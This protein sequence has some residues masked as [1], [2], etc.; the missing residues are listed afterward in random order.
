MC[1]VRA[2]FSSTT[3]PDCPALESILPRLRAGAQACDQTGEW[4]AGDWADLCAVG[5]TRWVLPRDFGGDELS[6]LEL[7][8]K[9]ERIASASLAAAL[10]LT[11][12]D[13]AI[14]LIAG[15]PRERGMDD[16][17]AALLRG[18]DYVTVGIA[19]LTTSRQ[20]GPPALRATPAE[21]ASSQDGQAYRVDG[22]IPWCTGSAKAAAVVAGAVTPDARQILFTIPV[23]TP[24]L[25]VEPPMQLA[26][27]RASW[28]SQLRCDGILVPPGQVLR[29]PAAN[30]LSPRRT[31]LP[32]GQA[33]LALG[34]CRAGIDLIGEHAS[35]PARRAA[36]QFERQLA[37]VREEVIALSRPDRTSDA[38]AA[39]P[40]LRGRCNDLAIR[41]THAAVALYKGSGLLPDHP[42]QRL[43]RES[44]FLL[45]WSCPT[46]VTDCTV[47]LLAEG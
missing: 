2:Y 1:R 32:L 31:H 13:A 6:P 30:V 27:L 12:R 28:T 19:Q 24:G 43:A 3:R 23:P 21:S 20:G 41:I 34:L 8:L 33:F 47:D 35:A 39:A 40:A 10:I 25:T 5:A 46:P 11:Q 26:A 14:D 44:M 4:P 17:T 42:A 36:E 29:G 9:Y 15:S 45:V 38:T 22:V 7:H 18:P 16:R 37:A